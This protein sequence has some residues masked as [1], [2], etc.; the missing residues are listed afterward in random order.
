MGV[1]IDTRP[2]RGVGVAPGVAVVKLQR[3]QPAFAGEVLDIDA[4]VLK[5]FVLVFCEDFALSGAGAPAERLHGTLERGEI[6]VG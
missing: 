3:K 6:D 5:P 4:T 2:P 1:T